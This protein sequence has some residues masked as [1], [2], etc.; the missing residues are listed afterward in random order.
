MLLQDPREARMQPR[1]LA[2]QQVIVDHLA[3]QGVP[4]AV[5]GLIC[6]EDKASIA[7]PT[8]QLLSEASAAA[9]SSP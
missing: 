9:S 5:P 1:V 2:R 4:E 3:Q 8:L 7:S 6:G